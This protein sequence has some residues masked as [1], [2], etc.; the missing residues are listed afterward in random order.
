MKSYFPKGEWVNLND[1]NDIVKSKG[2]EDGWKEL[3]VP[4]GAE[5]LIQA[6]IMPGA[7]MLK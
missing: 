3:H 7:I 6:H 2:G 1:Y 4:K 5:D